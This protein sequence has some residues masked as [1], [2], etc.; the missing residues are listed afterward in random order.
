MMNQQLV[1]NHFGSTGLCHAK[2]LC[3]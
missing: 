2:M 3:A 1:R